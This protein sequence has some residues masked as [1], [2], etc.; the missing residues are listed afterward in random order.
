MITPSL[1][2]EASYRDYI[3][4][5]ADEVRHPFP[6]D[7]DHEDFPALLDRM[8]DLEAGRNL[9]A[10]LVPS[11]TYWLVESQEIIAVSN[12]RHELNEEIL[13][14]GGHIGLGVRPSRRG[15]G[16]GTELMGL[17]IAAARRRGIEDVH[18]HCYASNAASARMIMANGGILHSTIEV[19]H[20][21]RTIQRFI[22][23]A[24]GKTFSP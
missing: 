10:G 8:A 18:V 4:E 22:V 1:E 16:L 19:G 12:L 11:S 13:R 15:E 6:L 20:P 21:P 2:Y 3:R 9:P 24:P 23:R 17:T 7:L 14:C 5:L